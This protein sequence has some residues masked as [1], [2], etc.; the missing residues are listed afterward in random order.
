MDR[1]R[2][3]EALVILD[4]LQKS[5]GLARKKRLT[6]PI[7]APRLRVDQTHVMALFLFRRER[8]NL[9]PALA[10]EWRRT[11]FRESLGCRK[12]RIAFLEGQ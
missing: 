3:K 5:L 8:R 11:A 4:Q 9:R 2:R 6:L 7:T 10:G 1:A 12:Q